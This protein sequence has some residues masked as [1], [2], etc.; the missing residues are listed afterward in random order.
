MAHEKLKKGKFSRWKCRR[1]LA[2][3]DAM[4]RKIHR[5]I[6]DSHHRSWLAVVAAQHGSQA[7]QQF[8][9]FEGLYNIVVGAEV[10][11]A[12]AIIDIGARSNHKDWRIDLFTT[13]FLQ[14]VNTRLARQSDIK[15]NRRV[16]TGTP[17]LATFLGASRPLD[18][19]PLFVERTREAA[20]DHRIVFNEEYAH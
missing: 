10:E 17:S 3:A 6:P 14:Q 18:E 16:F 2:V 15:Q 20:S 5:D 13:D 1:P 4:G 12:H 9:E 11:A 8:A 19:Y 7:R